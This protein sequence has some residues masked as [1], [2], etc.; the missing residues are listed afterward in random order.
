M[1]A[2]TSFFSTV[3]HDRLWDI[4]VKKSYFDGEEKIVGLEWKRRR[5]PLSLGS[6]PPKSRV[7]LLVRL[8]LLLLVRLSLPYFVT[9]HT[10]IYSCTPS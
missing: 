10:H 2:V 6:A 9:T 8:S 1:D 7:L 5:I 4:C 3:Y